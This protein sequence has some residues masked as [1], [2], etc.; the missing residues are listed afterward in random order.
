MPTY[1]YKC[2]H[3]QHELDAFQKITD[4]PLTLCPQ[5]GRES[6]K[7]GI[8]GGNALFQFQGEGFYQTDYK[9]SKK[10]NCCP[11]GKDKGSCKN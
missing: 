9:K 4:S 3:C 11:C 5:C 10:D 8:G 2:E 7:R 6:L 1:S